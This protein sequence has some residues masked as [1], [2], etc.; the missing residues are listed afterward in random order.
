[1]HVIFKLKKSKCLSI[2]FKYMYDQ[3]LRAIDNVMWA[4][5]FFQ[6]LVLQGKWVKK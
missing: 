2:L 1:M 5:S 3:S 4:S 6:P